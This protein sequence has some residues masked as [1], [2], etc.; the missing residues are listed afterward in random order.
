M[1]LCQRERRAESQSAYRTLTPSISI[2]RGSEGA[3]DAITFPRPQSLAPT[4]RWRP[5]DYWPQQ[6]WDPSIWPQSAWAQRLSPDIPL[7]T[8]RAGPCVCRPMWPFLHESQQPV[9]ETTASSMSCSMVGFPLCCYCYG[10]RWVVL[11]KKSWKFWVMLSKKSW[12]CWMMLIKRLWKRRVM[13]R[14]K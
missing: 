13:L 10:K 2:P 8:K 7:T 6:R 9:N 1:P 11:S 4:V 14:N 12:K 3:L 5:L